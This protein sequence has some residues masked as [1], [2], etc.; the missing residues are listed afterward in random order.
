MEREPSISTEA[1]KVHEQAIVVDLHAD[2]LFLVFRFGYRLEKRHRNPLP[3]SPF[4][5]HVD[6][7]RMRTG[8]VNLIG[9]SLPVLSFGL[10]RR[11]G[12]IRRSLER[13]GAWS[14]TLERDI[15]FVRQPDDIVNARER[16]VPSFFLTCEGAHGIRADRD[17][18]AG[19]RAMGLWSITLAHLTPCRAAF[20]STMRR[21][22]ARP[23]PKEGFALIECMESAG[24][25]VDLA[26]LGER[27][28]IDAVEACTKPPIV[29]HTGF[30]GLRPMWRN[31]SDYA[32]KKVADKNG[33]IGVVFHPGYLTKSLFGS[34]DCVVA[35]IQYLR[36]IAGDDAIALGSD[37]DGWV[38]SFP[39]GLEDIGMMP[40]LTERLLRTGMPV[41]TVK[42]ILGGNALRVLRGED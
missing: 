1:R 42:K 28:L 37:F 40:V 11:G 27:S 4:C 2:T 15:Q 6:I 34:V 14:K 33:V 25:I 31:I 3:H 36:S 20:P 35:A 39:A 32:A 29:S 26:H 18:I 23:L 38:P 24:M 17:E 10:G 5:V 19:Y 21:W 16:G 30:R 9:F 7:P 22:A 12:G 8:G 41:D 13:V